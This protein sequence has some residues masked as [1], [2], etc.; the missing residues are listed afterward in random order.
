MTFAKSLR[1]LPEELV[2]LLLYK[3]VSLHGPHGTHVPRTSHVGV[4]LLAIAFL[5]SGRPHFCGPDLRPACA[6]MTE[7][8]EETLEKIRITKRRWKEIP[9]DAKCGAL[10][11]RIPRV[12]PR[13]LLRITS[14]E[15]PY[16]FVVKI[17]STRYSDHQIPVWIFL[18]P[19]NKLPSNG[20]NV[21]IHLDFHGGSFIM[22]GP[23]EQ[24]PFCAK[25]ARERGYIVLT[26]DYC[27]GPL[28]Q[29]P[30]PLEDAEDIL[31]AVLD[32][33]GTTDG[34]RLLHSSIA[35][36]HIPRGRNHR[37]SS[38]KLA[39]T[40]LRADPTQI[41]FS[42]FSSG[43]NIALNLCLSIE[44]EGGKSWPSLIPK[45]NPLFAVILFYPQYD[46]RMDSH[47]RP[48][49]DDGGRP[50]RFGTMIEKKLIP[51][52]IP[53]ERRHEPRAS[54]GLVDP[55]Q[56]HPSARF[57]VVL[58]E[59]DTLR[60]QSNEWIEKV[61]NSG[62]GDRL[63]VYRAPGVGHGWANYPERWLQTTALRLKKQSYIEMNQFL[64]EVSSGSEIEKRDIEG[65]VD[66]SGY[67][68]IGMV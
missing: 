18:P 14:P 31:K 34:G 3:S 20:H 48:A 63:K 68:G 21:P 12:M 57:F 37:E 17:P 67:E 39:Q 55:K 62:M 59:N 65:N 50:G 8:A 2:L 11:I 4:T 44:N 32:T 33:E 28:Y 43:G 42:G 58:A 47:N 29:F 53:E 13:P 40:Q 5:L 60:W 6:F 49:P 7:K 16:P 46:Q 52:Y 51:M 35:K 10:F 54:P 22:G 25:L 56:L 9:W 36:H 41:S 45:D 24:A 26:T 64:D 61:R 1:F 30:T 23:F 15:G 66:N 19:E 27:L 38:G